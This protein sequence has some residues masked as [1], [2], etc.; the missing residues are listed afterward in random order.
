MPVDLRVG[1]GCLGSYRV[2]Y[3]HDLTG[4]AEQLSLIQRLSLLSCG[5]DFSWQD[6]SECLSGCGSLCSFAK[7]VHN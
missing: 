7:P 1:Y 3:L 2:L 5:V 4:A 6:F